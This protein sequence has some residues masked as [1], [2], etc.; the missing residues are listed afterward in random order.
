VCN[1]DRLP[2]DLLGVVRAWPKLPD[3]VKAGFL[4]IVRAIYP[5]P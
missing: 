4:A 3:S 5:A 1:V 2:A